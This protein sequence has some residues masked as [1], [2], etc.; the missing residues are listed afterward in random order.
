MIAI[1]G[2][3]T[4]SSASRQ[5]IRL[6]LSNEADALQARCRIGALKMG[7]R[8]FLPSVFEC[9]SIRSIAKGERLLHQLQIVRYRSVQ[10]CVFHEAG[11]KLWHRRGDAD[12][13]GLP[14]IECGHGFRRLIAM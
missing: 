14:P 4:T 9:Y 8:L 7:K 3:A 6:L 11:C 2:N 13:F 12:D 10:S 5:G 1:R